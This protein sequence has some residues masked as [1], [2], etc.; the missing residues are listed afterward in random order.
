MDRRAILLALAGLPG[1]ASAHAERQHGPHVHGQAE[2]QLAVEGTTVAV[3]LQAPGMGIV[4]FERAP[5]TA[6]ET[7]QL[8]AAT[9]LL[10]SGRWLLLPAAAGC[11]LQSGSASADG[12]E[13]HAD[14]HSGEGGGHHHAG[15]QV[16]LRYNCAQVAGLDHVRVRLAQDF[17][18]LHEVIV[19]VTTAQG[20]GRVELQAG[21][22]RVELPR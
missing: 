11:R 14:A 4:D 19:A 17:P 18:G 5:A 16:R 2:L 9:A 10:Q 8:K 20:Q 15:F 21:Q 7:T 1:L 3:A 22:E 12:F 13:P 6:A